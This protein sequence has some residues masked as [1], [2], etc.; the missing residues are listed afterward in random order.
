[1]LRYH[2]HDMGLTSIAALWTAHPSLTPSIIWF[3]TCWHRQSPHVAQHCTSMMPAPTWN[4]P[5][6]MTP[7]VIFFII[8]GF[9]SLVVTTR[10]ISVFLQTHNRAL[11]WA[12]CLHDRTHMIA[13]TQLHSLALTQSQSY[14]FDRTYSITL[15]RLHSI[16]L[17]W[18]RSYLIPL[19]CMHSIP[20]TQSQSI[21]FTWL[22]S[23]ALTHLK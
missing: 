14:T 19:D 8:L 12:I 1:M 10:N 11:K 22:H 23:N 17:V 9:L 3:S 2:W 4:S 20:L 15:I 21:A 7:S 16:S 5:V 6:P 13:L 18:T